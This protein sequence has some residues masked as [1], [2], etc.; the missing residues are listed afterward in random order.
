M[1]EVAAEFKKMMEYYQEH[2]TSNISS[3]N[4]AIPTMGSST[5]SKWM[6]SEADTP[7]PWYRGR[8]ALLATLVAIAAGMT[9]AFLYL[10]RSTPQP[11]ALGPNVFSTNEPSAPTGNPA[12][13]NQPDSAPKHKVQQGQATKVFR[14]DDE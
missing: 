1:A 5:D 3:A 11:A 2:E 10:N 9:G 6:L 7:V 14:V 13:S 8:G 4:V 12:G